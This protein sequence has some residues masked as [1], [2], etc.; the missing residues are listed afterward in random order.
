MTK[1]TAL[2]QYFGYDTFRPHQAEIIENALTNQDALVVMPTG[3]GKS[4]C[5]QLTSLMREGI[6]VVI[7]PIIPVMKERV[8]AL[9]ANGI[10]AECIHGGQ[11]QEEQHQIEDDCT[12]GRVKILYIS[13]ERLFVGNYFEFLQ[14]LTIDQFIVEEAH[15]ISFWSHDFRQEYTQLQALKATFPQIPLMAVTAVADA[16][17]RQ[18][19]QKQLGIQAGKAFVATFDR[20][21]LNLAVLP[22]RRRLDTICEFLEAHPQQAGIIYCLSRKTTEYIAQSL[23]ELGFKARNYHAGLEASQRT[24]IHEEFSKNEVQIIVATIAFGTGLDKSNLRWII[25]YNMP[26]NVESFY[27]EIGRA[28]RDGLPADTLILYSYAD[29]IAQMRFNEEHP[30]DRKE[31][32]NIKLD[33]MRQY[34]ESR[35]CRRKVLL[36]YFGEFLAEDCQNCDVCEENA[37][38][39]DGTV[40]AQKILS[41]VARTNEL[42]NQNMVVEI[43]RGTQKKEIFQKGYDKLKT[44]GVGKELSFDEW[45]EYTNQLINMG[46]LQVAHHEQYQLKLNDHSWEILK[47]GKTIQLAKFVSFKKQQVENEDETPSKPKH[48]II[49]DELFERLKG[50]CKK[51]ADKEGSTPQ[52]IFSDTSLWEMARYKPIRDHELSQITGITPEKVR[53]YG[54]EFTEF[55]L[56]FIRE[57]K[58]Q[59]NPNQNQ[60]QNTQPRPQNTENRPRN[61]YNQAHTHTPSFAPVNEEDSHKLSFQM[62]QTGMNAKQIADKRGIKIDAVVNHLVKIYQEDNADIDFWQ[63]I[64]RNEYDIIIDAVLSINLQKGDP[65]KPLYEDLNEEYD[66]Y[67]LRVA[68]LLWEQEEAN[69][70]KVNTY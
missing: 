67:K 8:Q 21:N 44:Y 37:T 26:R 17:T 41:C 35:I 32:L 55:I 47:N 18:D 57:K 10:S 43:L 70:V 20:P 61:N 54:Y 51:I 13:L 23:N 48:E 7:S 9:Q 50:L 45:T 64:D 6:T 42:I 66:Y 68:L 11:P 40:I 1:E 69:K 4:L 3:S 63:M 14:E 56:A 49:Q 59:S 46:F 5:Y 27:Q 25:H 2:K 65:L 29:V 38:K 22:G 60:N 36:S 16:S 58:N 39:I 62:Y 52:N 53:K 12:Q 34:C 15:C 19:I 30:Q 28:G 33:R 31:L 24:Q